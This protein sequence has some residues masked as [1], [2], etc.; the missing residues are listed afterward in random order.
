M[1]V[2]AIVEGH[3]E[4]EAIRTLLQRIWTE[5]LGRGHLEVL[6]PIRWPRSKLVQEKEL[7]RAIELARLKLEA[8]GDLAESLVLVLLDADRDLPCLLAPKLLRVGQGKGVQHLA[9]VLANVEYET[10]FIA[11][12]DS[13]GQYLELETARPLPSA[14]E[15]DRLGKAW[16]EKHFKGPKYSETLDQPCLTAR[17][18]LE[19]CRERS[20]SFAKLCRELAG[21]AALQKS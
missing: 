14:P 3:G 12:A 10:W 1:R 15:E 17:M 20:P 9:L 18:D 8:A 11:A 16:I 4:V 7:V 6:R 13:L 2:V 19:L 5:L 21:F